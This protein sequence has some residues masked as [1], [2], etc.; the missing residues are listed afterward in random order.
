MSSKY[1]AVVTP[2]LPAVVAKA[3]RFRMRDRFDADG[4]YEARVI[5]H[6][7]VVGDLQE[8]ALRAA[9]AVVDAA[10]QPGGEACATKALTL[11]RA[12]TAYRST[13]G[14]DPH[15]IGKAYADLLADYPADVIEQACRNWV[16]ISK[17]WP[18]WFDLKRECD[19]LC[20]RRLAE[21]KALT[22]ALA[23]LGKPKPVRIKQRDETPEER[24]IGMIATCRKHGRHEAAAKAEITLAKL[25][26][27]DPQPWALDMKPKPQKLPPMAWAGNDRLL[28]LAREARAKLLEGDRP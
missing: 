12:R 16:G 5:D 7:V 8:D 27:R 23:D 22:E 20:M 6:A 9:I 4:E 19:L 13:S 11:L 18:A 24:L 25:Q 3:V 28:E 15:I 2:G 10:C 21:H 14:G 1:L 17:W 26:G